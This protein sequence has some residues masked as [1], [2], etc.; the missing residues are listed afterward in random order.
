MNDDKPIL[1]YSSTPQEKAREQIAEMERREKLEDYNEAT[2]GERRPIWNTFIRLSIFIAIELAILALLPR[3][4]SRPLSWT[5]L[6]AFIVW[7][8]TAGL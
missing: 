6:I 8:V 3:G 5:A 2:F 1:E 7:Q 4:W